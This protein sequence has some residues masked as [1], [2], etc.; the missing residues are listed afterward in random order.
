MPDFNTIEALKKLRRKFRYEATR[1]H[2]MHKES[3]LTNPNYDRF[4]YESVIFSTCANEVEKAIRKE[5]AKV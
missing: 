3:R 5:R 4:W 2:N 1:C